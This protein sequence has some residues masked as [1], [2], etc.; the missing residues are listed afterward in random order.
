GYINQAVDGCESRVGLSHAIEK[1]GEGGE[2]SL[3]ERADVGAE[4]ADGWREKPCGSPRSGAR[5]PSAKDER[6][7]VSSGELEGDT[8]PNNAGAHDDDAGWSLRRHLKPGVP[9]SRKIWQR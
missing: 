5:L 4:P 9:R 6:G 8:E 2:A 7:N 1:R 3:E